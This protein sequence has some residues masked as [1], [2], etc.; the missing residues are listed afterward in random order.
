[1]L[2]IVSL[3]KNDRVEVRL[4]RPGEAATSGGTPRDAFALFPLTRSDTGCG[5]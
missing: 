1:M 2:S 3:Y 4:L 5:Y